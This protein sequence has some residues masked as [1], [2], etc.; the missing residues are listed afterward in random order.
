MSSPDSP[1]PDD[2]TAL[3]RE[4]SAPLD[5]PARTQG[6]DHFQ[7]LLL[8]LQQ[9][10]WMQ[11]SERG[12]LYVSPAYE[13]IWGRTCQ[14]LQDDFSSFRDA[15]HP[16]DRDRILEAMRSVHG[17]DEQFR[18]LRPDG[19]LRWIHARSYPLPAQEG[20]QRRFAGI[21]E[22]ITVRKLAQLEQSRLAAIIESSDDAIVTISVDGIV[23]G[24]N[25]GAE[26]YYGYTAEEI[27]GRSILI[28]F[29]PDRYQEYLQ[30]IRSVRSGEPCPPY[31][32]VRRRKDG[33]LIN[34]SLGISPIEAR[35][36]EITGASKVS[37]DITRIK[38]LEAQ[39][40]NM[41]KMEV[42]GQLAGGVAH[43][44]NNVLTTILGYTELL[45]PDF[46]PQ[47]RQFAD[48]EQIRKA[49]TIAR[50]LTAQLLAFS[51]QQVLQ[52]V[53]IDVN[54]LVTG[55]VGLLR[56]LIGENVDLTLA[57]DSSPLRVK[58][59][60]TQTEQVIMN[61]VVNARDAMPQGGRLAIA[62]AGVEVDAAFLRTHGLTGAKQFALLT[63]ADTGTGM[64]ARTKAR[65]F[66]PFF[67]T[68][69]KGH[70][71]GL[72]L[73]TVYGVVNQS[74]GAIVVESEPGQGTTFKVYLP[75]TAEPV[76]A[77]APVAVAAAT[78]GNETILIVEDDEGVRFLATE[79]LTRRGYR[80][81]VAVGGASAIAVE[82][83]EA[84]TIDLLL[85]DI[86][87]PGQSGFELATLLM[88]QRPLMKVLYI[89]GYSDDSFIKRGELPAGAPFLQKPF[90]ATDLAGK[91]RAVLDQRAPV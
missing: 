78:R 76:A 43:D 61:L 19:E 89:S 55:T 28:L 18:I 59:D 77:A 11:D 53:V 72:G 86:I 44:F 2:L 52:P 85:T 42:L 14:S 82:A 35:D 48:L 84:G 45:S 5:D 24:W 87:L 36:G 38:A 6:E 27:V 37:H 33:T 60:P 81:L 74:R 3:L 68:K 73:A 13:T 65:I 1:V 16:D 30:V 66:Q 4:P 83:A 80:V 75:V 58:V 20:N 70:G 64:D 12:I 47:S 29:P 63:V 41:Q 26:E 17:A 79:L 69:P 50:Q 34:V 21:A 62:T 49:A 7:A 67:T 46:D 31:D 40:A 51:R 71:T 25:Q 56:P 54:A 88:T 10:F 9:V 57:L 39:L 90:S 91:V 22:D 8:H 15:F 32:T 23:I